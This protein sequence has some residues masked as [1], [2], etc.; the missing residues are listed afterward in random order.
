MLKK[1]DD[2]EA[3]CTCTKCGKRFTLHY[4][5]SRHLRTTA[6]GGNPRKDYDCAQCEANFSLK[7]DLVRHI[8]Q[9]HDKKRYNCD[10]CEKNYSSKHALANH[11]KK[12]SEPLPP[13]KP[14][15]KFCSACD[16][17]F[18]NKSNYNKHIKTSKHQK[19]VD[20]QKKKEVLDKYRA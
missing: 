1:T 16:I 13:P 5:L 14:S 8:E 20:K 15:T 17:E 9:V 2:Y 12:H 7:H 6:C 4:N 10:Q 18:N 11:I 3:A 19:N